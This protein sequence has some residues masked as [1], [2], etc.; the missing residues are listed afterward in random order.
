MG[1][2]AAQFFAAGGGRIGGSYDSMSDQCV[3]FIE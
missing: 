2:F 3:I 1:H